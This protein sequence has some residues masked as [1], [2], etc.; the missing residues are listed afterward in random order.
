MFAPKSPKK[1]CFHLFLQSL[2]S[3]SAY[4]CRG[5]KATS[6]YSIFVLNMAPKSPKMHFEENFCRENSMFFKNDVPTAEIS[7]GSIF[8]GSIEATPCACIYIYIVGWSAAWIFG[9]YELIRG[10]GGVNKRPVP[11]ETICLVVRN[12]GPAVC[13][14]SLSG[15]VELFFRIRAILEASCAFF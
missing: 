14:E 6:H 5:F 12:W 7:I 4:V 2:V 3:R 11:S 15:M 13:G 1:Q 10:R 9:I 8:I